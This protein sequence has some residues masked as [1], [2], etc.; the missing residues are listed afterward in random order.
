MRRLENNQDSGRLQMAML[1]S[2]V[3]YFVYMSFLET[4]QS[5]PP[6][7]EL[8]RAENQDILSNSN[9]VHNEI[10][11]PVETERVISNIPFH[12]ADFSTDSVTV[13]TTSSAGAIGDAYLSDFTNPP[14]ISTW[15]GW[16]FDREGRWNP[17]SEGEDT[18]RILTEEASFL[19]VG[20]GEFRSY[21]GNVE[22]KVR[23]E[24]EQIFVKQ[25]ISGISVNKTVSKTE[26]P[27]I[28]DVE[29]KLVNTTQQKISD[30]WIGNFDNMVGTSSR[31]LEEIRPQLYI[32]SGLETFTEHEDLN[33]DPETIEMKPDW[34]GLGSRYFLAATEI[35]DQSVVE[36][37]I[38]TSMD[39]ASKYGTAV[40][41]APL[42]AGDT[43]SISMKAYIGPK[44][45]EN[46]QTLSENWTY[47]IDYG[48]FG[49]FSR[50]LLF[51]LKIFFHGFQN[52]GVAILLLTFTIKLIFYPLTQK[53]F[54]SG[55]KMQLLQPQLSEIKEKY[56][57]NQQLQ[58]QETMKL[59]QKH[60]TSPLGGCLPTMIQIPVWFALYNV[61]LYSVELY[62]S[63]F[64][65][66]KDL[67]S[68][69]PYGF[70]PVLYTLL[71]V[72]QMRMTPM[73]SAGGSDNEMQQQMQQMMK[74]MPF[75]FGVFM[76]T[77]PSG[78]V[79]YFSLNIFL[80]AVQQWIIRLQFAEIE[81]ATSTVE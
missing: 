41:L 75:L 59:F 72:F 62:D 18:L 66:L 80:T 78:L 1:L 63:S 54:V 3:V 47:A 52:W 33:S 61:M 21:P 60:G 11:I 12:S 67:T 56:K 71:M 43:R 81:L 70:L 69:D 20:V 14:K 36:K 6:T 79:L 35:T 73:S 39:D 19:A 74:I 30:I 15:W 9:S 34:F 22:I 58:A 65:Y 37:T 5:I 28:F 45:I 50:V 64:L 51:L 31:F 55:R 42:S 27:Y 40:I 46:L 32:D 49:F 7:V 38:V 2:I 10:Q 44:S 68:V 53:A 26:N 16:L 13:K 77:F 25:K 4:P 57:D 48:I 24:K 29:L 76:F 17:Y 8:P 23:E